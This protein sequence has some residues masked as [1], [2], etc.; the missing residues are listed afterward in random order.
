M[1]HRLLLTIFAFAMFSDPA[2]IFAAEDLIARS[3][4]DTGI[5]LLVFPLSMKVIENRPKKGLYYFYENGSKR[6]DEGLE[7]SLA[8]KQNVFESLISDPKIIRSTLVKVDPARIVPSSTEKDLKGPVTRKTLRNWAKHYTTNVLL[9]FR[10]EISITTDQSLLSDVYLQP[11]SLLA[12][13]SN[14]QVALRTTGMLYLTKQKKVLALEPDTRR[15]SIHSGENGQESWRALAKEGLQR[16]G[17]T[18]KKTFQAY[19]FEKRRSAY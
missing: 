4:S 8:P 19:K 3:K 5:K 7:G 13:T 12:Q 2:G 16:L 15:T 17:N 10:R 18:A 14:Y 6:F 11:Q 1:R 9:I